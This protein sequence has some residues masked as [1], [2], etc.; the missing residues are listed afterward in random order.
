MSA[1]IN[2]AASRGHGHEL[3]DVWLFPLEDLSRLNPL[4]RDQVVGR[5]AGSV[6]FGIHVR[7]VTFFPCK[8]NSQDSRAASL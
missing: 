1:W 3:F 4:R 5:P 6:C 8:R 2:P 7:I